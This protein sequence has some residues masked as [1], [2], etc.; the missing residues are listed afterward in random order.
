MSLSEEVVNDKIEVLNLPDGYPVV[1]VRAATIV[2]NDDQ[3]ISRTFHRHVLT[4]DAD[5][6]G[7]DADVLE[8]AITVFTDDAK[9]A[10]AARSQEIK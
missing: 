1:Q 10:Y 5:L 9:A 6:S 8:I 2:M 7:E 3:E 4:P